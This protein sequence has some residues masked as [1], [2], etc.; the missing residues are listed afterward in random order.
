MLSFG[1]IRTKNFMPELKKRLQQLDKAELSVGWQ[2]GSTNKEAG[3]LNSALAHL[4]AVG[5]PSKNIPAR[6]PLGLEFTFFNPV[7]D[8]PFLVAQLENVF[9]NIDKKKSSTVISILLN[10]IG[11]AWVENIKNTMGDTS[12]LVENSPLTI[13]RKGFNSPLIENGN[14]QA[15][16]TYKII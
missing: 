13:A 7:W 3:M 9:K 12:K 2:D 14:L 10:N 16:I 6:D 5:V 1:L 11:G 8:N 15:S 4:H